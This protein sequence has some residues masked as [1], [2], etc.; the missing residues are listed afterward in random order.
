MAIAVDDPI[1]LVPVEVVN[2]FVIVTPKKIK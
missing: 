2:I 1:F